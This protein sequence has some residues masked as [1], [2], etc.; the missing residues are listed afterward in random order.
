[1]GLDM[2]L[3]AKKYVNT[4]VKSSPGRDAIAQ[5]VK[6]LREEDGIPVPVGFEPGTTLNIPVAYWR[7]ANAI[8]RWFVE[9]V[10][11]G[12][13]ECQLSYVPFEK[14]GE[15]YDLCLDVQRGAPPEDRLPTQSGF[16]FGGTEYDELYRED[17]NLTVDQL[18]P[19]V[20]KYRSLKKGEYMPY[21]LY[22]RS[23]W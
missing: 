23:S 2:Y 17:I 1:M 21:D 7:K 10:Q 12:V 9:A 8:H 14:L 13:D 5:A 16:F 4:S 15:L 3:Y 19:I 11:D 18:R 20:E 22:Y 6:L